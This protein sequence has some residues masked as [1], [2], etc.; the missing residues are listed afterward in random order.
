MSEGRFVFPSSVD[1]LLKG[2]GAKATP[3]FK[4]HL[5]AHGLEVLHREGTV[6]LHSVDLPS[7]TVRVVWQG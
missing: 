2:L 1:G 5:K 4:A 7:A 6:T 3:E